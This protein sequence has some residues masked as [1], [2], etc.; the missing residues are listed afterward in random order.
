MCPGI[1]V[2]FAMVALSGV[3]GLGVGGLKYDL[4]CII[5]HDL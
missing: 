2:L 1:Q 3:V 4:H 5:C